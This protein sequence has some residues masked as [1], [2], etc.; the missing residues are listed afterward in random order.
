MNQDHQPQTRRKLIAGNWK[1]NGS[2]MMVESLLRSLSKGLAGRAGNTTEV[3]VCPP[4]VYL[5]LAEQI[6]TGSVIGLGAQSAS[7]E[8]SGAFTGE[9]AP[10]MLKEFSVRYVLV[11]HSERRSLFGETD[12]VVA[13]K[14]TA[15]V[16]AGLIPVLCVGESL[17]Q[18][19]TNQAEQVVA[20][21]IAAVLTAN[22]SAD[23]G[24]AVIAYEPVWAIGTGRTA[25]PEQAQEMHRHIRQMLAGYD[26][27]T[28]AR[29]RILYG[30]SV[31]ASNAGELLAK[32][33][34]DGA[35]VGGASLLADEFLAICNSVS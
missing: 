29:T 33:D 30:G 15:L 9:I 32:P 18:R 26:A 22:P 8:E 4:A 16:A 7:C 34:I 24:N 17:E 1:L 20:A 31:N 19:E 28:A 27:A 35:L 5:P 14:F 13:G 11:G 12:E 25:T 21:Q 2:R 23:F 6:L 3:V 10:G